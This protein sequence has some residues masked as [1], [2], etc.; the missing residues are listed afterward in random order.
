MTSKVVEKL[1]FSQERVLAPGGSET[2][3]S[4][5]SRGAAKQRYFLPFIPGGQER[6]EVSASS[7]AMQ[8]V[9]LDCAGDQND[10]LFL[11]EQDLEGTHS[12]SA[13][14]CAG[15]K[16]GHCSS[17]RFGGAPTRDGRAI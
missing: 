9:E 10:P 4:I 6:L 14:F 1:T 13:G 3:R 17:H 12:Q 8:G 2:I 11:P 7:N 16:I 15:S 5:V